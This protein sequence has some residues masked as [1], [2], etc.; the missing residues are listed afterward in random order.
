MRLSSLPLFVWLAAT[1]VTSA[2]SCSNGYVSCHPKGAELGNP[3]DIGPDMKDFYVDLVQSVKGHGHGREKR[4]LNKNHGVIAQRDEEGEL[5]WK[6]KGNG[7]GSGIQ[8]LFLDGAKFPFCWVSLLCTPLYAGY[9]KENTDTF[10]DPF[11]TNFF[12]RDASHGNAA[13]GDYQTGNGDKVNL[14]HGNYTKPDGTEENIYGAK[15]SAPALSTLPVPTP[16]TGSG[17]GSPIPGDKLGNVATSGATAPPTSSTK[18]PS[19]SKPTTP[20]D[21]SSQKMELGFSLVASM[22]M[23]ACALLL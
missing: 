22:A 6:G 4:S 18:S 11:T 8:C 15:E 10:Q 19:G 1:A 16:F 5:C 20:A 9:P 2:G 12:F 17:V 7:P 21:S 13:T 23:L 3:P 14:I